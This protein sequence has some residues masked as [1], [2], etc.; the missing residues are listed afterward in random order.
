MAVSS[1]SAPNDFHI[2]AKEFTA[3]TLSVGNLAVAGT[4][5]V[6]GASTL[7]SV[8]ASGV[9]TL[10]GVTNCNG[11][12]NS[13]DLHTTGGAVVDLTLT[14]SGLSD[15]AN[16]HASG[17]V[18]GDTTLDCAGGNFHVDGAGN[19]DTRTLT[20]TGNLTVASGANVTINVPQTYI[21][22]GGTN[23]QTTTVHV[24]NAV[25][26]DTPQKV[27]ARD[28][29]NKLVS[30]ALAESSAF[31]STWTQIAGWGAVPPPA[32]VYMNAVRSGAMVFATMVVP[33]LQTAGP[34]ATA[35]VTLPFAPA[36]FTNPAAPQE[37]NGTVSGS[38]PG[39]LVG[40]TD[41]GPTAGAAT[42]TISVA[43]TVPTTMDFFASFSYRL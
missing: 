6:T 10:N 5:G 42:A 22:G 1:L 31:L 27:L 12:L 36:A 26:D 18:V 14:V 24:S 30:K 40:T 32:A 43:S 38:A 9:A 11:G 35:T 41:I 17:P 20:V 19:T 39:L 33:N 34:T 28:G 13:S 16:V 37:L 7:A 23:L 4:L 25:D 2:Y 8:T 21:S 29:A 3:P 15:L